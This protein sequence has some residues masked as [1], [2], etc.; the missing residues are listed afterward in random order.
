MALALPAPAF[1]SVDVRGSR[2][3][4]DQ[5]DGGGGR[6]ND[7]TAHDG[8]ALNADEQTAPALYRCA[9]APNLVSIGPGGTDSRKMGSLGTTL[10]LVAVNRLD[11]RP[12]E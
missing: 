7:T 11:V 1:L 12:G 6:Y 4:D 8:L 2:R 5:F 10:R 9:Q 3:G